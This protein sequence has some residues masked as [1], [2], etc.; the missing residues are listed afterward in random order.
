MRLASPSSLIAALA[1]ATILTACGG[2]SSL[3]PI[4]TSTPGQLVI[5]LTSTPALPGATRAPAASETTEYAVQAGD[6][7]S[8]IGETFDVTVDALVELNNLQDANQIVVGQILLI[9]SP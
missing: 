4:A 2:S 7:L 9:P 1:A 3:E 6:T 5:P 8:V